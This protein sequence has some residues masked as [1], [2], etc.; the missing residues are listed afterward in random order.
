[1]QGY[2]EAALF[3][4]FDT[5]TTLDNAAGLV[6]NEGDSRANAAASCSARCTFPPG[7]AAA[8]PQLAPQRTATTATGGCRQQTTEGQPSR[9]TGSGHGEQPP[10]APAVPDEAAL[11]WE[12]AAAGAPCTQMLPETPV[13]L[14]DFDS[15]PAEP[16]ALLCTQ[17]AA[18]ASGL[19]GGKIVHV[20]L[21][22]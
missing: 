8:S 10:A 14:W 20:L 16:P 7:A 3:N 18:P 2:S 12:C 1:M 15:G 17:G 4:A 13:E 11:M 6:T 21:P 19:T 22:C 5:G 9:L